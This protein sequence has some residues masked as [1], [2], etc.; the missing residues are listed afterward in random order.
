LQQKLVESNTYIATE[1][2][3]VDI[4][5]IRLEARTVAEG[6]RIKISI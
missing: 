4:R 6:T 3:I 5:N 1:Y 2:R